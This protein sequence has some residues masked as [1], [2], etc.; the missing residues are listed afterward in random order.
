MSRADLEVFEQ[1]GA[2]PIAMAKFGQRMMEAEGLEPF[3]APH[4][5]D[6]K[7]LFVPPEI[8]VQEIAGRQLSRDL[9]RTLLREEENIPEDA[10]CIGMNV[11]NKDAERKSVWEQMSAF[12]LFH[13]RH[14]D[15]LLFLHTMPHP[16]MSGHDLI[17][18]ADFLGIGKSCR[19][20]DPYSLLAGDYTQEDMAK[21][22]ARLNLYSGASRGEGFGLPLIEAQACGVPVVATN[23]SAMT[24]ISGPGW[25]VDGQPSWN[26]GHRSTWTIPDIGMLVEAYNDA[27]DGGAEARSDDAR[28][29]A[30]GYDAD[31]VFD[32]HWQGILAELEAQSSDRV[33]VEGYYSGMDPEDVTT[34]TMAESEKIELLVEAKSEV[35][36]I[37][38]GDVGIS[39]EGHDG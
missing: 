27:Y 29:F 21:W 12:A 5:I 19:W 35:R 8:R 37:S 34:E 39:G 4:G 10:F 13:H 20:A 38:D 28:G 7:S 15:S 25:L 16:V 32:R 30:T 9:A 2:Q 17:G 22:Y 36:H 31:L 11:H 24:E 33:P 1:S 14:P 26:R 6:T 23:A 18:M 3:Y